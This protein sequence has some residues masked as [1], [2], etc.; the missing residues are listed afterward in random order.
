MPNLI[1]SPD[2]KQLGTQ[3]LQDLLNNLT[4]AKGFVLSQA[5]EFCQ[6]L[7]MR[8]A[9]DCAVVGIGCICGIAALAFLLRLVRRNWDNVDQVG[10]WVFGGIFGS[11]AFI[12]LSV[13]LLA[14]IRDFLCVCIAPKVYLV[15][16]LM[17]ML[18]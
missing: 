15:E 3:A 5:P 8:G 11:F 9:I 18:K 10:V 2:L 7:V 6:Q 12:G 13:F 16:T 17:R 14:S 1:E 4:Q